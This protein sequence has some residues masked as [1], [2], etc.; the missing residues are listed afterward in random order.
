MDC[1][2]LRLS[3]EVLFRRVRCEHCTCDCRGGRG[4]SAHLQRQRYD[5]DRARLQLLGNPVFPSTFD[6]STGRAIAVAVG[7]SVLTSDDNGATWS[8]RGSRSHA[9]A[10][11]PS[12]SMRAPDERLLWGRPLGLVRPLP[13]SPLTITVH[14]GPRATPPSLA[15]LHTVALDAT[16]GRV[17]AVGSSRAVF[18]SDDSGTTWTERAT[19]S[20]NWLNSVALDASTGRAVAVGGDG[21]CGH[22]QS[23]GGETWTVRASGSPPPLLSVALD[24]SAGRVIAVG[25]EGIVLTS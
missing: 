8:E 2:P 24:S 13:C 23:D 14:H 1:T 17:F 19:G 11:G 12:R 10:L 21:H 4:R 9:L 5:L 6:T 25:D 7:G 15:R 18:T 3:G 20:P 22:L 16:S